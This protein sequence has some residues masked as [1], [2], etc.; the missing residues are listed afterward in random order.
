MHLISIH[1]PGDSYRRWLRSLL[2]YSCDVLRAII[3]SL[4]C[5]VCLQGSFDFISPQSSSRA[6]PKELKFE[7]Q[8]KKV[9]VLHH[10]CCNSHMNHAEGYIC[11]GRGRGRKAIK[12]ICMQLEKWT[13]KKHCSYILH[14]ICRHTNATHP[15]TSQGRKFTNH[16]PWMHTQSQISKHCVSFKFVAV[17]QSE[18]CSDLENKVFSFAFPLAQRFKKLFHKTRPCMHYA[19][20]RGVTPVKYVWL[21]AGNSRTQREKNKSRCVTWRTCNSR[22]ILP[23][24]MHLEWDRIYFYL[25]F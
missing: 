4:V 2:L 10:Y 20:S 24:H 12:E 17:M 9:F 16:L 22:S 25:F 23:D 8:H 21:Q 7:V 3:N 6:S 18:N 11:G 15:L 1:M 14:I 13:D 19:I 5:W